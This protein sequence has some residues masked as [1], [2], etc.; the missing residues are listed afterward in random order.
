MPYCVVNTMPSQIYF[1]IL[2]VHSLV[3]ERAITGCHCTK[4]YIM[5]IYTNTVEAQKIGYLFF[6]LMAVY[7]FATV[8]R[9]ESFVSFVSEEFFSCRNKLDKAGEEFAERQR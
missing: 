6:V 9:E 4:C 3:G 7:W 5:G 2:T 8:K 1:F